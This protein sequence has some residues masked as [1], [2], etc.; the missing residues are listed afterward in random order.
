MNLDYITKLFLLYLSFKGNA[1][2]KL[3]MNSFDTGRGGDLDDRD[4]HL[5]SMLANNKGGPTKVIF[6][7]RAVCGKLLKRHEIGNKADFELNDICTFPTS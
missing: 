5:L 1:S 7:M 6:D 4:K 3:T 2:S